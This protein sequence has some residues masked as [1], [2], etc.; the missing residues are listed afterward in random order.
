MGAGARKTAAYAKY[1]ASVCEMYI[2]PNQVNAIGN[3]KISCRACQLGG[4]GMIKGVNKNV[5]EIRN[6][7]SKYFDRAI[8][9]LREMQPPEPVHLSNL[10]A[11]YLREADRSYRGH[12]AL[13]IGVAVFRFLLAACSGAAVTILLIR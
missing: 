5:I 6:P 8:L 9:F 4:I 13:K 11:T 10:A 3:G 1:P 2:F 12:L 7:D